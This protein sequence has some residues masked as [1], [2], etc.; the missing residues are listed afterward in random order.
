MTL[1]LVENLLLLKPDGRRT[2]SHFA[3]L[4]L[5]YKEELLAYKFSKVVHCMEIT[6]F[7]AQKCCLMAI[8]KLLEHLFEKQDLDKTKRNLTEKELMCSAL[9]TATGFRDILISL[10]KSKSK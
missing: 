9:L 2:A 4:E 6:I 3:C 1:V 5:L 8:D 7:L 10:Q